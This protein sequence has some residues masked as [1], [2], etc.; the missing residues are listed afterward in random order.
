MYVCKKEP[1]SGGEEWIKC[2]KEKTK[3]LFMY[4]CRWLQLGTSFYITWITMSTMS[5]WSKNF[6]KSVLRVCEKI[7]L[8]WILHENDVETRHYSWEEV[9]VR[10][11]VKQSEKIVK[12]V[13]S[14]CL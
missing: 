10:W 3:I 12:Y 11:W 5:T 2:H 13:G 7:F 14:K 9:R 4:I 8:T 1:Q 6:C